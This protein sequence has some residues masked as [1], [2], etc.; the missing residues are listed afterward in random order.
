MT[1]VLEVAQGSEVPDSHSNQ[2]ER[3]EQNIGY[4]FTN[5]ALLRVALRHSSL[6]EQPR[7]KPQPERLKRSARLPRTP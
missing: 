6:G 3:V 2:L 4:R 7:R 1:G 5:P